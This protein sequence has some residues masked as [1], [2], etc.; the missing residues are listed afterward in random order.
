MTLDSPMDSNPKKSLP[1]STAWQFMPGLLIVLM[2]TIFFFCFDLQ[3]EIPHLIT[4]WVIT[5]PI[6]AVPWVLLKIM[7]QL[8]HP[9]VLLSLSGIRLTLLPLLLLMVKKSL[10][11]PDPQ[12]LGWTVGLYILNLTGMVML[13]AYEPAKFGSSIRK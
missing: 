11:G 4:G 3:T 5:T 10:N 2:G 7:P 13:E 8:H 1:Y 6:F 9:V 12:V